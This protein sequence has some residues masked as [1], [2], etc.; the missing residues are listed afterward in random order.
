MKET[1]E[2]EGDMKQ[3]QAR[4]NQKMGVKE[5]DTGLSAPNLWD[6]NA[7]KARMKEE[8]PLQAS[9]WSENEKKR[10]AVLS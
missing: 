2:I 3:I 6:L 1:K 4:V 8:Q 9:Q 10:E 5:T 7:D